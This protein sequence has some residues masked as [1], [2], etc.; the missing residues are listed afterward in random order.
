MFMLMLECG[1]RVG[2]VHNLSLEDV[3]PEGPPRLRIHGKGDKH[4]I[5]YLSPPAKEVLNNWLISRPTT[6][7]PPIAPH[8]R[9][10]NGRS[11]TADNRAP[12]IVRA[13]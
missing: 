7:M 11:Q 6:K 1:L 8:V 9:Q 13:S 2:E 3:L 4:R 12:K 10:K 5:A